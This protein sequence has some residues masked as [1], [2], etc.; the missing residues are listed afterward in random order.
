MKYRNPP[1]LFWSARICSPQPI[2]TSTRTGIR[3]HF[4]IFYA[5]VSSSSLWSPY[6]IGQTIIFFL[7]FFL[8]YSQQSQIGC[9]PYFDT[10]CSG[11]LECMPKMCCTRLAENTGCKNY[12]KFGIACTQLLAYTG[13]PATGYV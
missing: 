5:V 2:V 1:F 8:T 10:R 4:L 3:N 9:L 13:R 12:A 11:N 7:S 6:G